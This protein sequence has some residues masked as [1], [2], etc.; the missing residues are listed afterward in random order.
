MNRRLGLMHVARC[1]TQPA[2]CGSQTS[3]APLVQP[4]DVLGKQSEGRGTA[5]GGT[6]G[7]EPRTFRRLRMYLRRNHHQAAQLR[8]D[9]DGRHAGKKFP[10]VMRPGWSATLLDA[11]PGNGD[12]P[13]GLVEKIIGEEGEW[14]EQQDAS[15]RRRR[16]TQ[17][18]EMGACGRGPASPGD[19]P[20]GNTTR[21]FGQR[22]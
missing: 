9:D 3:R 12:R 13:V 8:N 7:I 22:N 14:K 11:L 1:P 2:P 21:P 19:R 16:G 6:N 15:E 20:A 18:P 10:A 17:L 5:F 4:R